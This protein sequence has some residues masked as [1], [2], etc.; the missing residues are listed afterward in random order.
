MFDIEAFVPPQCK[1]SLTEETW[2]GRCC[3]SEVGVS[4]G[5]VV[6]R[7]ELVLTSE[8]GVLQGR[9]GA[10]AR[11]RSQRGSL[12]ARPILRAR[13]RQISL[14]V[15][16]AATSLCRVSVERARGTPRGSDR[17]R[18]G[19][20]QPPSTQSSS[21]SLATRRRPSQRRDPSVY[22]PYR[23][24]LSRPALALCRVLQCSAE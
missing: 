20:D 18:S 23:P 8:C 5:E 10:G 14:R 16:T 13:S 7:R 21:M 15:S 3:R 22:R 9:G 4:E 2:S 11:H 6:E 24:T 19:D 17:W 1:L 12:P